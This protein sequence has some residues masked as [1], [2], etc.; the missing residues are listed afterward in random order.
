MPL[1]RARAAMTSRDQHIAQ[2]ELEALEQRTRE[3]LMALAGRCDDTS[4]AI[5]G[6]A[7]VVACLPQTFPLDVARVTAV[8]RARGLALWQ[9]PDASDD[10][11]F[12]ALVADL[13]LWVNAIAPEDI[14][15]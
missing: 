1:A 6:L 5:L 2:M 12:I 8:A 9:G 10:M 13:A 4:A 14:A 3:A 7:V 15:A 11:P